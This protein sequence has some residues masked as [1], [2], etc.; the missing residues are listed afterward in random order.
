MVR[1]RLLRARSRR[2]TPPRGVLSDVSIALGDRVVHSEWSSS[3]HDVARVLD[4]GGGRS[5]CEA[6]LLPPLVDAQGW[7]ASHFGLFYRSSLSGDGVR[8]WVRFL[9]S[10]GCVALRNFSFGFACAV[11]R[12]FFG[13][14]MRMLRR[15]LGANM[16]Q[17]PR[18]SCV[19]PVDVIFGTLSVKT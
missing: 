3:R 17:A 16:A 11:V 6:L 14:R 19:W 9:A 1:A 7:T 2:I 8:S 15:K 5:A 13:I 18:T 12:V 10:S 4:S